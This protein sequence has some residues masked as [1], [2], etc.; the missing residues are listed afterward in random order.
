MRGAHEVEEGR[1]SVS[2]KLMGPYATR[3]EAE[4]AIEKARQRAKAWEAEERAER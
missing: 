2:S 1:L 3:E 4:H